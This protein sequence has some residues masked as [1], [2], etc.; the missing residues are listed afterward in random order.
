LLF[1]F[2]QKIPL[3]AAGVNKTGLTFAFDFLSEEADVDIDYVA[4]G[5]GVEIIDV[6]PDVG[7]GDDAFGVVG[8]VFEEGVFAAAEIDGLST[9]ADVAMGGIDFEIGDTEDRGFGFVFSADECFDA[10]EEFGEEEGL[11]EIVVGAEFEAVDFVFGGV[12]GGEE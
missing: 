2:G 7:A 3:A 1:H 8:E 9:A 5:R 6:L 10:C 4:F 11:D 12:F